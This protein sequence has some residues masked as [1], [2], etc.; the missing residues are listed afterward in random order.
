M[1]GIGY[2]LKLLA[3]V[4]CGRKR[5]AGKTREVG[6]IRRNKVWGKGVERQELPL[7]M[8]ALATMKGGI[9]GTSVRKAPYVWEWVTHDG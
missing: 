2:G 6:E 8:Q 3:S 4:C 5:K 9:Q 7:R 1:E